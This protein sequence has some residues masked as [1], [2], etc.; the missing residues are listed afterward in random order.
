MF[1]IKWTDFAAKTYISGSRVRFQGDLVYFE[2]ALMPPSFVIHGW[3]SR[4]NYQGD[5]RQPAL[6]RLHRGKTYQITP[7]LTVTPAQSLYVQVTYFDRLGRELGKTTLKEE[8]WTFTYP[9]EAFSYTIDL[10]NAGCQELVFECLFLEEQVPESDEAID[11]SDLALYFPNETAKLHVLFLEPTSQKASDLPLAALEALGNVVLVGDP[12]ARASAYLDQAFAEGLLEHLAFCVDEG[13][14]EICFI[15]YGPVGQL[16]SLYY[17]TK[18]VSQVY[19]NGFLGSEQFYRSLVTSKR[20][21]ADVH[22]ADL[23]ERL[24]YAKTIHYYAQHFDSEGLNLVLPILD[25]S[26]DLVDLPR[27]MKQVNAEREAF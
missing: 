27:V 5:R 9:L 17:S 10:V 8:E 14:T 3:S 4:T 19:S 16:A 13:L 18:F 7:V 20:L 25:R 23:L 26:A 15:A 21:A 24:T 6:P 22:L 1:T 2:N 11:F 12:V